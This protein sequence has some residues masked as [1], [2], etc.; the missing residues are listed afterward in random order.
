[1]RNW[2]PLA[3]VAVICS[4]SVGGCTSHA[5]SSESAPVGEAQQELVTKC[6][7]LDVSQYPTP[8]AWDVD[9][10]REL[11]IRD[12]SVVED[13]CRT[14]WN[15]TVSCDPSTVGVWTF[16]ALM[17]HM[18]GTTP[19]EQFVAEWLNTFE[20]TQTINGFPVP[21]R[22][23]VRENLIDPWL[24]ASG[25]HA[26][27][28]IVG[29]GACALDLKLAPFRLTA[30]VNRVDLSGPAYG[31]EN[32]GEARFVF[33]MLKL[34]NGDG[35]EVDPKEIDPKEID[36]KGEYDGKG[37]TGGKKD[38]PPVFGPIAVA[39]EPA[40]LEPL[41]PG[42]GS[43]QL[44]GSPHKGTVILEYRIP[45]S[46]KLF[47]WT[48]RWHKLS[49]IP[50]GDPEFNQQLQ[51]LTDVFSTTGA[52]TSRPN[53][54]SS[55]GQVR[56]NEISLSDDGIWELREFTLQ[57]QGLGFDAFGLRNDT[58]KQT[59]DDSMNG[60]PSLDS[61]MVAN[62]PA[63]MDVDHVVPNGLMGGVSRETSFV[64]GTSAGIDPLA[65]HHFAIST[66]NGCHT[67]A[68]DTGFTHI[69]NRS[70]GSVAPLSNF[71]GVSP[72]PD[73]GLNG[74]PATVHTVQDEQ[75]PLLFTREYNEPWRRVCEVHRLL[76]GDS[77]PYTRQNGGTH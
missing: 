67:N 43:G 30:I 68:T 69:G 46:E 72:A 70:L 41:D 26:G 65:R 24:E 77:D 39:A 61:W 13:A 23:K 40:V 33:G 64:W 16:G 2:R 14:T 17:T 75:F 22:N 52:D 34:D 20:T 73:P 1:M 47:D 57:D 31:A 48:E 53:L 56:T 28:P 9:F 58:T 71:L 51:K 60:D 66:C 37:G 21:P 25:C 63:I 38:P 8:L 29:P 7:Y 5:P 3:A 45:P 44:E 32:P 19:P 36:P 62:E 74:L 6:K 27:D 35:K 59:P 42:P 50:L 12:L 49:N 18:A 55:I 54:G 15:P 10:D 4:A 11:V 76:R